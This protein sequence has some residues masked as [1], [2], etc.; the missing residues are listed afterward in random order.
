VEG[1]SFNVAAGVAVA[2]VRPFVDARIA[3]AGR[4]LRGQGGLAASTALGQVG[5][6]AFD[7]VHA[8]D[9]ASR[10]F[11]AGNS[12]STFLFGTDYGAY[13]AATGAELVRE[14]L[15]E[16]RIP[17]TLRLYTEDQRGVAVRDPFTLRDLVGSTRRYV[18]AGLGVEP[19]R[20]H[21]LVFD[22][23]TG[24]G[25]G[26]LALQW[27]VMPRLEA[28]T[29]DFDYRRASLI[30]GLSMP[31]MP[32]GAGPFGGLSLGLEVAAGSS[33]GTVP[34]QALWVLGGPATIRGY[35]PAAGAGDSFWRTRAELATAFPAW[36]AVLFSDMGETSGRGGFDG[37]HHRLHSV[38]IGVSFLEGLF[39]VDLARALQFHR[40]WRVTFGVDNLL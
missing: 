14:A 34:G 25:V 29:G 33:F 32:D 11:D 26:P 9:P 10:P 3:T 2:G 13:F 39:R 23:A 1:L 6:V 16:D 4:M 22:L 7:R 31:L 20:Q 18:R 8:A 38:G 30:A 15:P 21:G 24:G 17:W 5:M 35:P 37:E 12:L 36:R 19:A 40:G 28:A 27:R